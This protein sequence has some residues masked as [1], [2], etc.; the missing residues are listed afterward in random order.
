MSTNKDKFASGY[1]PVLLS[2]LIGRQHESRE[3]QKLLL[4]NRLVTLTGPGGCGKT[5]L[6]LKVAQE[7]VGDFDNHVWFIELA[8]VADP[9]FVPQTIAATLNVREQSRRSLINVLTD[10]LSA[11]PALLILDN[12]EHLILACAQIAETLLNNCPDLT[13]LTTSR[14]ILGITGEVTWAVPPL[15]LPD[16]QP[17]TNPASARQAIHAYQESESVQ[18]FVA[19]AEASAPDFQL[20]AENGSWVAEICRR[21]DGIPLAIE[22]AAARV[23]TL[24]VQQIARRLDDRFLLLTGGSR[25]APLRHQTLAAALDW[26]YA[27]LSEAEQNVLQGLSIFAGGA[28]LEALEWVCMPEVESDEALEVLSHLV[29]KSLVTVVRS[30]RGETRYHLLETIRQYALEKLSE[31]GREAGFRDC[32]LNYFIGWAENAEA[33]LNGTEQVEWLD[34]YEAE[35]DNLRAALEWSHSGEHKAVLGLRLAAACG[36]FWR[37]HG[38][39]SEGRLHLTAALSSTAAQP[40]TLVRAR[41]LTFLANHTYLQSDYP[42]MRPVAEEALAI[43]RELGQDGKAGAAYT[44][45]LLGELATEEGDYIHAP[46]LFQE[47]MDIYRDLNDMRGISQIHMQF[48]WAAMRAGDY[49][50]AQNHL[51]EFFHLAQQV[52]DATDLAY[53]FSGLGEVAVRQGQYERAIPLLEQG[54]ALNREHGDRWGTGTLLGSLGW[55]A[56]RQRDF[57]RMI[58]MLGESLA[59]RIEISDRGGIAW[60]LEKL[61][62]AKYDQAQFQEAARIFGH[63]E[64]VRAPIGSVIDPADQPEYTRIISGLRSALGTQA[65]AALWAEGKTMRIDEVID[66]A[67]TATASDS[68][69]ARV[70]KEKFGGLTARERE[71]AALIAQGKSNREIAAGMTVGVKTVETYVTR[72]LNK[73]GFDSRVQIAIWAVEKGLTS[74]VNDPDKHR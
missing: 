47:A 43:W 1:L 31:S 6:A 22:L 36:R 61:A 32:H 57:K 26:S 8:T 11:Y 18:L 71:A 37:L 35:H 52:G 33:Y 10:A 72:I 39:L 55:I 45:D 23:R 40:R 73:L 19:R 3:V 30:E 46:V 54:L 25:T 20:S 66:C 28:T 60:C 15:S 69:L 16:Q 58:E 14:E 63:A 70:E 34:S 42:G 51:E 65:F 17:W 29:D 56:L 5:R 53:A 24:S 2:T 7:L 44:L 4:S 62:E 21:L 48:G 41:A 50:H 67:L 68:Q 27:L 38:Y 9:V 49:S 59:I 74:P 12:C 13:I 64:S